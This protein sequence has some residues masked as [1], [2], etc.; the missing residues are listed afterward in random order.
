[1]PILLAIEIKENLILIIFFK[2]GFKEQ[3]QN[4]YTSKGKRALLDMFMYILKVAIS[5]YLIVLIKMS[6]L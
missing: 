5:Q 4:I 2:S 1:M 3:L 6:V